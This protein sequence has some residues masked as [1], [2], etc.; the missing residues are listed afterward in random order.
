[1]K[2]K[3]LGFLFAAVYV[4]YLT[5]MIFL[6]ILICSVNLD[7]VPFCNISSRLQMSLGE[8]PNSKGTTR[9]HSLAP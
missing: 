5:A 7:I 6:Q 3:I 9:A 2:K 1:M 8:E 4:A